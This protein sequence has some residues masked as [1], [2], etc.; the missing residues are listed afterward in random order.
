MKN[1]IDWI[2]TNLSS[3]YCLFP[4]SNFRTVKSVYSFRNWLW[5]AFVYTAMVDYPTP[6]NFLMNLPAYPIKEVAISTYVLQTMSKSPLYISTKC[7]T[8]IVSETP[9]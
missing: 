6:A 4:P 2:Y 8:K 7:I 9:N 3:Q 1:D 5:T